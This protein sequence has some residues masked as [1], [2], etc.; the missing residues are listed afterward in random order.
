MNNMFLRPA[1][2]MADESRL[3]TAADA[4]VL[5]SLRPASRAELRGA[6]EANEVFFASMEILPDYAHCGIN[7]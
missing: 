1:V 2:T 7:E 5:A 6:L 4:V 3:S